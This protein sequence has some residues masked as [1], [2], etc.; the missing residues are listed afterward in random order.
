MIINLLLSFITVCFSASI[1]TITSGG[2][3]WGIIDLWALLG[4]VISFIVIISIS[5]YGKTFCRIFSSKK[6][7]QS[8]N[9]LELQKT[10]AALEL[11]K[12]ILFYTATLIPVLVLIYTLRNY[13]NTPEIYAHLGPNIAVL[14]ISILFLSL[15]EMIIYTLKA[16]VKKTIIQYM[17]EP[18]DAK[19]SEKS[20]NDSLSFAKIIIG[21]LFFVIVSIFYGY[22]SGLYAWG[23]HSLMS[24]IID[25]RF[26][27]ILIVKVLLL[28]AISGNCKI[29]FESMKLI[30]SS[31]KINVSQKNLYL[32]AV[33]TTMM[34]NWYAAFSSAVCCWVAI[35]CNLEDPS[36]LAASFSV[37]FIPFFY[38]TCFNLF[39]L[40]VEIRV[41][42][43]CE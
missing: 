32:N 43:A 18:S 34:L 42:K 19:K 2:T 14:F 30:F 41:S 21:I 25:L 37:S 39:L 33:K 3:I 8:L 13:Y 27:I 7:F 22:I 28:I 40:L 5:G 24:A 29:L 36:A 26:L 31:K 17:A 6:S 12:K 20:K 23:K 11:G 16:K 15:F 9:L 38:A 35:L 4:V 10:D 1:T